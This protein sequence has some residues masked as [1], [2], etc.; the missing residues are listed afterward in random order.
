MIAQ[1]NEG[2]PL[3]RLFQVTVK[4]GFAEILLEKFATTSADVVKNEPG[5]EGYFFGRGTE[6]DE[7]TLVFAS[8]WKDIDAIKQRFGDAW[9]QSF[10]PEGY[11]DLIEDHSVQH[12]DLSSGWHVPAGRSG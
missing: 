8:L 5:N 3:L 1:F 9:E 4:R 2:G 11:E 10:L 6:S 12:I 7:N